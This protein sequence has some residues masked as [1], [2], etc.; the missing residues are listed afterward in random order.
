MRSSRR[1]RLP[2]RSYGDDVSID[3]QP[4]VTDLLPHRYGVLAIVFFA[5]STL[6][7]GMEAAYLWL[8]EFI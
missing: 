5:G 1:R 3:R 2:A 7:V 4:R 6:I 8:P